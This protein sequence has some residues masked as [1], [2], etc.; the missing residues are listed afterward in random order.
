MQSDS[1]L[2]GAVAREEIHLRS[3]ELQGFK[4][5]DGLFEVEAR[6]QDRKPR[7]FNLLAESRVI[8]ANTAIHDLGICLVF[9]ESMLIRAVSTIAKAAPYRDCVHGGRTL[10]ALVGKR[11][12]PGWAKMVRECLPQSET[13]THLRE[14]LIPIA[15][16]AYQSMTAM[17]R[18]QA[19][20][21]GPDGRPL[22]LDSCYA[23]GASREL[24]RTR[25]PEFYQPPAQED[26]DGMLQD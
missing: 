14:L 25:W 10:Q 26:S 19:T 15:T 17:M 6:L 11:I 4:R 7:D 24:A 12:G 3:I 23:Y 2:P 1:I 9:D 16:V 18:E 20:T 5:S 13:C 8:P 22:K 21:L